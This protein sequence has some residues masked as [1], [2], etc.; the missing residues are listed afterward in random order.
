MAGAFRNAGAVQRESHLVKTILVSD[1]V[2]YDEWHEVVCSSAVASKNA[3]TRREFA[4]NPGECRPAVFRA[5]VG[6]PAGTDRIR[7]KGKHFV[8]PD[9]LIICVRT[10]ELF[11]STRVF[12]TVVRVVP[13]SPQTTPPTEI[14]PGDQFI[15]L[16]PPGRHGFDP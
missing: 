1:P 10:G 13:A 4:F 2:H 11:F 3:I 12:R 15:I 14:L 16:G 7:V 5:R 8:R 9:E 6:E